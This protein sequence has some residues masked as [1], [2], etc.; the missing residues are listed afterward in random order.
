MHY[1]LDGPSSA[2]VVVLLNSL[3][4]TIELW[5]AQLPALRQRFRVLRYD[6]RGHGR[7]SVPPGPYAF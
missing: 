2:P 3:G 7:S 6:Q 4:T 5:D 1:R